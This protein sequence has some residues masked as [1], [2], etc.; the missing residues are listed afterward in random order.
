M[1]KGV[2]NR[3]RSGNGP[4][5]TAKAVRYRLERVGVRALY[6]EPGSPWESDYIERFHGKLRAELLDR[7]GSDTLMVVKILTEW[8]RQTCNH[9]RPHNSLGDRPRA[10]RS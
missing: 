6:S 8:F 10:L 2:P 4:E 1:F 9:I 7:E 5:F 3:I